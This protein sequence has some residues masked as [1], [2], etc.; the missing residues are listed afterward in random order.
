MIPSLS[1]LFTLNSSFF[2]ASRNSNDML[3]DLLEAV[4]RKTNN[5]LFKPNGMQHATHQ[6]VAHC[7]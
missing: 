4:I 7:L 6:H 5:N 3:R 1:L 2:F